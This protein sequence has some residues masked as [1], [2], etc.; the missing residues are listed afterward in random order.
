MGF[1]CNCRFRAVA[2]SDTSIPRCTYRRCDAVSGNKILDSA[3]VRPRDSVYNFGFPGGTLRWQVLTSRRQICRIVARHVLM[4]VCMASRP[5]AF[6]AKK[7]KAT[8]GAKQNPK[9]VISTY[10]E[11]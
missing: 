3:R 6:K 11:V 4:L 9:A 2:A 7:R 10:S 5:G 1:L 8:S